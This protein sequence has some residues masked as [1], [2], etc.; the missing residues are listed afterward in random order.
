[1]SQHD[2][3]FIVKAIEG[4]AMADGGMCPVVML[5]SGRLEDGIRRAIVSPAFNAEPLTIE[6]PDGQNIVMF[7]S[8]IARVLIR[9]GMARH[10]TEEEIDEARRDFIES[11]RKSAVAD[12][13]DLRTPRKRGKVSTEVK[14]ETGNDGDV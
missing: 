12:H 1:M 14:E 10:M 9:F 8:G 7:P 2:L 5:A 13:S 4:G 6:W 3:T 11:I